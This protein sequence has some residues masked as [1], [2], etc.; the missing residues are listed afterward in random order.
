MRALF[1]EFLF[2]KPNLE[3]EANRNALSHLS[4]LLAARA[5]SVRSKAEYYKK[6]AAETREAQRKKDAEMSRGS[7]SI[8]EPRTIGSRS[9]GSA[10][11]SGHLA[12]LVAPSTM[13]PRSVSVGA[14]VDGTSLL[15]LVR[16][17]F[18]GLLLLSLDSL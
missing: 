12:G 7:S 18:E 14:S 10:E 11:P 16:V 8:I 4:L 6:L 5:M 3:R 15:E 9:A 1:Y 2:P 17:G 13:D